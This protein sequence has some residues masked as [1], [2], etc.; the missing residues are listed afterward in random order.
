[1]LDVGQPAPDFT[2][3]DENGDAVRLADLRG[4]RRGVRDAQGAGGRGGDGYVPSSM[5][6]N[7][8]VLT[9]ERRAS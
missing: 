8:G 7:V 1:M 6:E 2:L 3:P 4:R 5:N 9:Y